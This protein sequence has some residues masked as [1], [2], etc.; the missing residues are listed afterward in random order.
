MH[1]RSL[2]IV[3]ALVTVAT[4]ATFDDAWADAR[5]KARRAFREGMRRIRA[6][7]F[8]AGIKLLE[9]ANATLPH[10]NV[11]FNIAQ[12][13][14]SVDR[15]LQAAEWFKRYLDQ[16]EPPP[17]AAQIEAMVE[18][19]E[20]RA[21]P[22]EPPRPPPRDDL[23]EGEPREL[24][25]RAAEDI[26]RLQSL[27]DAMRPLSEERA[28]EI[29]GIKRRMQDA[30][31]GAPE[32]PPPPPP[33]PP[34]VRPP[35]PI[36][37]TEQPDEL[38]AVEEYQEREV[39]T[40]ATRN[41]A[42]PQD[43]PAVVWVIT[44][45]EIRTRGYES[46]P[47]ALRAI[48]GLHVI[49][50]HVFVDVGV[51][52][53]HGGLRGM[54]RIIKV[55]IDDHP[56]TFRPTNGTLLGLELIPIRAVDRIELVRG[57][58]SALYGAN[59][60][61][62][63]L[64]IITRRGGDV[65]G[66][67]VTGRVGFSTSAEGADG[68]SDP[69]TSGSFDL[70]LGTQQ[71]RLSVLAA[72]QMSIID[73]SGLRIPDTSPFRDELTA[74][75]GGL[76]V[77]DMSR[78]LSLFGTVGYDFG[79][80]GKFTLMAGWQRVDANAEWLDYGALTH[81]SRVRLSNVWTRLGYDVQLSDETGL[82]AFT[83]YSQARPLEGHQIRP[84][85]AF[86]LIPD[87]ARH[88]VESYESQAVLSGLE[89]RWELPKFNLGVRAGTDLDVDIEELTTTQTVFDQDVGLNEAGST[90]LLS[91]S[92]VDQRTF[93]N[94]G[95][96]LQVLAKP[97][98][99]LD[100]IGGLRYDFHSIYASAVN[101]R[102]GAVLRATDNLYFKALYGS[103]YRAPAPDQLYR[104]PA[105]IGDSIGCLDY[106]PCATAGIR[107][108][109]AHTGELVAGYAK[110]GLRAQATAYFSFVDDYIFSLPNYA[111]QSVTTNA[112]T[113]TSRGVELEASA[114]LPKLVGELDVA[115]HT[116]LA[117]QST[118]TEVDDSLFEPPESV[119][120]EYRGESLSPAL[121]AGGGVDLAYLPA[122]IGLYLEGRYVGPRRATGSNLALSLGLSNY[123][124]NNLPGYF[125]LD[126]NLSTRDL[127]LFEGG[128]TV[129]SL[130]VTDI[131]GVRHAEG[132]YRGWD[133]PTAGR[134]V[135]VRLIQEY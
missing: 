18:Q 126:A 76:S 69:R 21:A 134:L 27:A 44:Q 31:R 119:R 45:Q 110:D 49:D 42:E 55:L 30:L 22:V 68:T 15:P 52:G 63:V 12:A 85:S 41:A 114:K 74:G 109:V 115:A 39:V 106:D 46:V 1:L 51:R 96:Y 133:I 118:A 102:L 111:N 43:A 117:F 3:T 24:G 75:R 9:E 53:I 26:E 135:F 95:L 84:L 67:A 7:D 113:Y 47:E 122:K 14:L 103:A 13:Y 124:G 112:G 8:E 73:R 16:P 65:G 23:P 6:K 62:G 72:A 100:V 48:A 78:P 81:F 10:P 11:M 79:A 37:A 87:D 71:G 93:T 32:P 123:D 92:A 99:L 38:R 17:D 20:A 120:A 129:I 29:V 33:P 104:G 5:T 66:G 89:V 101:G 34:P 91:T 128:E 116:Y 57:P 35:P 88:F 36:V 64:Q 125:E 105:Y 82:R 4:F 19:L 60:F 131:I 130:R 58:G 108:Q 127:Y 83:S 40:A 77:D 50:D 59:A 94:V 54:S 132:G 56:V 121:T 2:S 90:R 28:D 70:V 98:A 25:R 80:R 107:P 86:S 61:L 97:L